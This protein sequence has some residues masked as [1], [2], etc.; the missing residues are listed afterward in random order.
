MREPTDKTDDQ[1]PEKKDRAAA[2][3]GRR[4]GLK[5]GA[6]RASRMTP[7]ERAESARMAA[8]ARWARVAATG[9]RRGRNQDGEP[10]RF[11]LDAGEIAQITGAEIVGSGGLQTLLRKLHAQLER[12]D[13]VEFDNA[14]LGQLVRY[15]TRIGGGGFETRLRRAF[16]RSFL[17]LFTPI[18]EAERRS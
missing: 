8:S 3:L 13:T 4:G 12:G 9:E 14:G 15:M 10:F 11:T 16:G 17:D 6:I 7:E 2:E 1:P 5:G 18:F